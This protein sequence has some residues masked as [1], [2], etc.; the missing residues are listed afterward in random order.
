VVA[1]RATDV[2]ANC[3]TRTWAAVGRSLNPD[4]LWPG[5]YL[6]GTETRQEEWVVTPLLMRA[7]RAP[8]GAG[9]GQEPRIAARGRDADEGCEHCFCLRSL[10]GNTERFPM[11][12]TTTS[13]G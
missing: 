5:A 2:A 8:R 12:G 13:A 4:D 11:R 7:G 1:T 9:F 6:S 3:T 10:A